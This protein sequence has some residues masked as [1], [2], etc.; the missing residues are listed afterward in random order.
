MSTATWSREAWDASISA[1]A[2]NADWG[3]TLTPETEPG[4]WAELAA[5]LRQEQA[6]ESMPDWATDVVVRMLELPM[7]GYW[8][9]P[10]N[11]TQVMDAIAA[12]HC[13]DVVMT[14]Y[15]VDADRKILMSYYVFCLDAWSKEA[16]LEHVVAELSS[17]EP[18]GR[19][20]KAI[21]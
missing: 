10:A 6:L 7:C 13:P 21:T 9:Y 19:D 2:Y 5:I 8:G 4:L 16:P 12:E 20:W 11:V 15:T 1:R 18:L 14:C 3:D 17:R